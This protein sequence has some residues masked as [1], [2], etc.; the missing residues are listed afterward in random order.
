[1]VKAASCRGWQNTQFRRISSLVH[2]ECMKGHSAQ[3]FVGSSL[4]TCLEPCCIRQFL[5]PVELGEKGDRQHLSYSAQSQLPHTI[6]AT[7]HNFSNPAQSQ[8]PCTIES[9][10]EVKTAHHCF[11]PLIDS[12]NKSL[13]VGATIVAFLD[14]AKRGELMLCKMLCG[15][16]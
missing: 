11:F 12:D 10:R 7:L 4:S 13:W 16:H 14:G 3:M 9:E 1:M 6:S 2:L 5:R 8:Q 15:F